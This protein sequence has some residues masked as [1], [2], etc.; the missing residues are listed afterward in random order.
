MKL[1]GRHLQPLT[2]NMGSELVQHYFDVD[3][4]CINDEYPPLI[5]IDQ[6]LIAPNKPFKF[7]DLYL[8]LPEGMWLHRKYDA[9]FSN[10]I[11]SMTDNFNH[12]ISSTMYPADD[13]EDAD[14]IQEDSEAINDEM[15][16]M[17]DFLLKT[18]GKKKKKAQLSM[19]I[20]T[21]SS[22]KLMQLKAEGADA[23]AIRKLM[24]KGADKGAKPKKK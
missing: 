5:E 4:W 15:K 6:R 13:V 14:N 16:A 9:M 22:K 2:S 12:I 17:N 10:A 7:E 11:A 18:Q 21:A 19:P 23:K 3:V 8:M 24:S 1:V 20:A